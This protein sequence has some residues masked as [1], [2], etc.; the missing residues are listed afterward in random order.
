MLQRMRVD[1]IL[2][3]AMTASTIPGS[4]YQIVWR[5][6][7]D[8]G[9]AIYGRTFPLPGFEME[10]AR[11]LFYD[12]GNPTLVGYGR[13]SYVVFDSVPTNDSWD[14]NIYGISWPPGLIFLPQV[15]R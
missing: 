2:L 5:E 12:L 10:I 8:Q 1:G 4:Q 14:Y 11:W 9:H 13:G 15:V 7:F 6:R 3:T